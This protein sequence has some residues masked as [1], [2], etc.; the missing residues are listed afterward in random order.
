MTLLP[1]EAQ[2]AERAAYAVVD[3]A[4]R[5]FPLQPA[6]A[7]LAPALMAELRAADGAMPARPVFR[8][9]WMDFALSGFVP[10]MLALVMLL[11]G[12]VSPETA[13][14][15]QAMVAAPLAQTDALLWVLAAAGL[16]LTAGLLLVAGLVFR[17]TE[18]WQRV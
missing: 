12:W 3:D 18:P 7:G 2:A 1:E 6:P 5:S 9:S 8:L 10:L 4:L 17:Q 13:A 15:L 11:S 16:L 14:R